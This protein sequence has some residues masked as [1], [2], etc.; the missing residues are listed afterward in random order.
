MADLRQRFEGWTYVLPTY[1]FDS[2]SK[3]MDDMLKPLE[4]KKDDKAKPAAPKSIKDA[5]PGNH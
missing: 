2:L 4:A 1:R 5:L 3:G